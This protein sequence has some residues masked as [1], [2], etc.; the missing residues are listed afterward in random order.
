MVRECR[1]PGDRA[2]VREASVAEAFA[3]AHALLAETA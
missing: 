2:A 1:F 3:M